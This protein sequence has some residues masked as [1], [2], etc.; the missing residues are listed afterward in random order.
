MDEATISSASTAALQSDRL[1][2]DRLASD[3]P[4]APAGPDL[5]Q[6][7]FDASPECM[8]IVARDGTILH[9]NRAGLRIAQAGAAGEIVGRSVLDMIAPDH[10]ENWR[11]NH[12][13]VCRGEGAS[14]A[15]DLAGLSGGVWRTQAHA[16]PLPLPDGGFAHLSILRDVPQKRCEVRL[17]DGECRFR[18]LAHGL[19]DYAIFMLDPDG[20]VTTLIAAGERTLGYASADMV[21]R[22]VSIFYTDEEQRAGVPERA[23]ANARTSGRV[24]GEGWQVRRDGSRFWAN[25]VIDAIRDEQGEL[26]G[27]AAVTRDMTEWRSMEEQ[28][29]QAQK[30]EA[31]GQLTGGIAHDFNNILTAVMGNIEFITVGAD[32][33]KVRRHAAAALRAAGRGAHLT[34]QLLAFS[35]KQ[36]LD[37]KPT[38]LN[39]LVSGMSE[40]LLLT[41]GST[42]RIELKLAEA[43]W[44]ALVDPNEI[45][46]ALLN[47]AIN[48]RDAMPSGGTL[49]IETANQRVGCRFGG[50][51]HDDGLEPGDYVLVSVG[52]TGTGMTP[53]VRTRA[54]EPFFTTK[55]VGR[56]SGLGLSQVYGIVRQSGGSVDIASAVGRGTT[57]RLLLPRAR[58][59]AGSVAAEQPGDQATPDCAGCRILLVDDNHDVRDVTAQT[60]GASGCIVT[61]V[62]GGGAALDMLRAHSFDLLVTDFAMPEMN[63]AELARIVASQWPRLPVLL[64]TGRAGLSAL[65]DFADESIL[66][67]PF[68]AAQLVTKVRALLDRDRS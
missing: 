18:L 28:L 67:K 15:F 35:R 9:I 57:V 41:L 55:D 46:N 47:L 50:A 51:P 6:A 7:V 36:R 38:C 5:L 2:S 32:G 30:M 16:A 22:H 56:G 53:A 26:V 48:A 20:R 58:E 45:E 10:R 1:A 63:G 65:R 43:L 27:F 44:E 52:D 29:R 61:A 4:A 8:M 11:S 17:R 23:L 49:T 33:E 14:W 59:A 66:A 62:S 12:E 24:E 42:I 60:L 34:R 13:R 21:G 37:P 31:V 3:R 64:I 39:G 54:V 19:P 68:R 40:I 25:T